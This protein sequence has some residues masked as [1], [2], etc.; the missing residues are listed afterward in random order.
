MDLKTCRLRRAVVRSGY[1]CAA[2]GYAAERG[3]E[4]GV[5]IRRILLAVTAALA[6][7][8]TACSGQPA[9]GPFGNNTVPS[10]QCI[11]L[12][13][14]A[15]ATYGLDYVQNPTSTTAT[16]TRVYLRD[17][18]GLQV[19]AAWAVPSTE[20]IYGTSWGPPPPHF[21]ILGWHWNRRQRADGARVP[22]THGKYDR[23]NLALVLRLAP[24]RKRG[25]A[26]GVNVAYRLRGASYLIRHQTA[27]ILRAGTR[28]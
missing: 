22:P 9:V 23:L 10:A 8:V 2:V 3:A 19:V 25:R 1:D 24:G 18:H 7:A 16:L 12:A 21:K 6:A 11:P 15:T 20:Q 5:M 17:N 27:V 4:T 26:A 13:G 14:H 28:C